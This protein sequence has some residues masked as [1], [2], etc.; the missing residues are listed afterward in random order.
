MPRDGLS[1]AKYGS[2]FT[3]RPSVAELYNDPAFNIEYG[4]AMMAGLIN[5]YGNIR[6]ALFHYGPSGCGYACYADRIIDIYNTY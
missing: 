2:M 4:T 1:G 3:S 5:T 6:D